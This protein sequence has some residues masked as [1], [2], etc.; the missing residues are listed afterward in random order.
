MTPSRQPRTASSRNA[1]CSTERR[2]VRTLLPHCCIHRDSRRSGAVAPPPAREV[3]LLPLPIAELERAA[4]PCVTPRSAAASLWNVFVTPCG[5]GGAVAFRVAGRVIVPAVPNRSLL[6][7]SAYIRSVIEEIDG[8][9]LL[10][11]HSYGGAVITVAGLH[12]PPPLTAARRH[13][14]HASASRLAVTF[15]MV[16]VAITEPVSPRT[17][18]EPAPRAA[19]S[20]VQFPP[21]NLSCRVAQS[22]TVQSAPWAFRRTESSTAHRCCCSRASSIRPAA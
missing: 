20:A 19:S 21:T 16:T 7:D 13:P 4:R 9:V 6:G 17:F 1:I 3:P 14:A 22:R 11:G 5:A 15:T 10:A 2:P 18:R 12:A 8:P